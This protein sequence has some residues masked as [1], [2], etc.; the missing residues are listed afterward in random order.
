MIY[1]RT[2]VRSGHRTDAASLSVLLWACLVVV[3]AAA[4]VTAVAWIGSLAWELP[5]TRGIGQKK[6][7]GGGGPKGWGLNS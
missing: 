2:A 1:L 4:R 7:K 5:H 6:K 3:L